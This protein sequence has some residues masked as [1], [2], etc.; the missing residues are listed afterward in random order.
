MND[1]FY[2]TQANWRHR[3]TREVVSIAGFSTRRE[4]HVLLVTYKRSDMMFPLLV[5]V[6]ATDFF[7]G[8]FVRLYPGI[9]DPPKTGPGERPHTYNPD[10]MMMGDCRICGHTREAHETGG[11]P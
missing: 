5:T 2:L 3:V 11:R 10:P 6:T 8:S 4:D 7:D 1:D 9:D